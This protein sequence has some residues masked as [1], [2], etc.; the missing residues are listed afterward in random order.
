ML[1][2]QASEPNGAAEKLKSKTAR[3]ITE[4][5]GLVLKLQIKKNYIRYL[6]STYGIT[7]L[8]II[9]VSKRFFFI[10]FFYF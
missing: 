7:A 2:V 9:K 3:V 5:L 1:T 8:E 10:I 6:S 4:S